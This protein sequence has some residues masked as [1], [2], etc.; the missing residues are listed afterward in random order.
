MPLATAAI[1]SADTNFGLPNEP[2]L[3]RATILLVDDRP[4]NLLAL[5]ALLEPLDCRLVRAN[6]GLDALK[7]LLTHDIALILM[8]VQM[9]GM[10]G[11]EVVTLIKER[12][13]SRYIPIIFVTALSTQDEYVFQGYS[14]GAVDYISK[15]FNPH[16]LLSKV[17][18]FVDLWNKTAEIKR[19][20]E[21][22][23]QSEQREAQARAREREHQAEQR[24]LAALSASE[25]RFRRVVESNIFGVAFWSRNGD[26]TEANDAFLQM[27]GCVRA[28]LQNRKLNWKKLTPLP[29]QSKDAKALRELQKRGVTAA[30][31]KELMH[32]N[33]VLVPVL[34]CAAAFDG[35]FD[36]SLSANDEKGIYFV[37]NITNLKLAE[38]SLMVAKDE[39]ETARENAEKANRAKSEFIS[40]VSHELRTPLNAILGFSKL[41]LNPRLG[42]LNGD[43]NSCVTDVVQSAE[44]LLQIINDL[45]DLSKIEAGKMTL[46]KVKFVLPT[47]LEQSL[48]I[49]R[50]KAKSQNLTL[51]VDIAPE[52][53]ELEF[54]EG[55]ERKIRQVM[56]NLLSNAVKFTPEGGAVIVQARRA[57]DQNACIISVQDTG[58]GIA[59]ENQERILNAFEQVDLS[60]ARENQGTGLGLPLTKR[61]VELHGGKLWLQSEPGQGS[62]FSFT[63]P[64]YARSENGN[65]SALASSALASSVSTLQ[66]ARVLLEEAA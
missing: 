46:D 26:I 50:E 34:C 4:E 64:L 33:G 17:S 15:P 19:Q 29:H 53:K 27:L 22:L 38:A 23:R 57:D 59:P 54:I 12:E 21:L 11:F 62:T 24:H 7:V 39:A 44:H 51:G 63:L 6:S 18:V 60:Y 13:K 36:G 48:T 55:D 42:P 35:S 14:A 3:P 32:K 5:E 31:E 40:N 1:S 61:I 65:S 28:D 25:A 10:D 49:V 47:L 66:E 16:I 43:Q 20:S 9:P 8:D 52:I 58:I 45:L 2:P 41:L 56:F 30:Y 37:V